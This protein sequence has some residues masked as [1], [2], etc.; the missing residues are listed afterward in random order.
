MPFAITKPKNQLH[1]QT[2]EMS[3]APKI[4]KTVLASHFPK[5]LF[6]LTEPGEGNRELPYWKPT[7]HKS[8]DTYIVSDYLDFENAYVELCDGEHDFQTLVIDTVDNMAN[9]IVE[10]ILKEHGIETLNDGAMAYGRGSAI[11]ES[12][13]R[14]YLYNF[15][16]LPMGLILISHLK[17]ITISRPNKEPQTAWRDTLND[18]AKGIV[19][20]LVDMILMLR[21]EGRE[22]FIY[23]EGDLSIEAG[24]RITLPEQISMGNSGK[25]AYRNLVTAFY[26]GN[27]NKEVAKEKLV[28]EIL[29]GESFLAD[30]KIDKFDT[31]KR[32]MA[33]RKKHL[34]F[35]EIEKASIENLES[36]LQHLAN[37]VKKSKG[38]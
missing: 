19:H 31:D 6:I 27:T 22:R 29:K 14:T 4:G 5:P 18:R 33:S 37:K 21:K 10:G 23:T 13:L 38:D 26:S 34:L 16:K 12:R 32:L 11:F 35:E 8:D 7:K 24:S 15:A 2:I 25:D 36:Y 20:P 9:L 17:E 1:Q 30:N 28:T 3:G